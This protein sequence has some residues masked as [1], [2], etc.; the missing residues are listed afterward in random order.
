MIRGLAWLGVTYNLKRV[1][2]VKQWQRRV[3]IAIAVPAVDDSYRARVRA[4]REALEAQVERTRRRLERA[5]ERGRD[6]DLTSPQARAELREWA[7]Q[8]L[9]DGIER[10][11]ASARARVERVRELVERIDAYQSLLETLRAA[12]IPGS[13]QP[14]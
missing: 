12:E 5:I 10:L 14:A 8:L 13:L 3:Q 2:P 9:H 1:S 7:S 4:T 11:G 6:Y